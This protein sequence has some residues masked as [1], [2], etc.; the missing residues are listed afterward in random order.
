MYIILIFKTT[1][2]KSSSQFLCFDAA[3]INLFF[4]FGEKKYKKNN[5]FF[6]RWKKMRTFA[7]G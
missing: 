4:Q 6:H 3:K 7:V 5:L 2:R 1:Q